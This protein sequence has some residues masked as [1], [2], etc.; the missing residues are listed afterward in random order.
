MTVTIETYK[1]HSASASFTLFGLGPI[2][3]NVDDTIQSQTKDLVIR[4]YVGDDSLTITEQ[5]SFIVSPG[6]DTYSMQL[7]PDKRPESPYDIAKVSFFHSESTSTGT[8]TQDLNKYSILISPTSNYRAT[9]GPEEQPYYLMK[10]GTKYNRTPEN[11]VYYHLCDANGTP[12]TK[13]T[14]EFGAGTMTYQIKAKYNDPKKNTT[15]GKYDKKWEIDNKIYL[16]I[17]DPENAQYESGVYFSYI[18][19]TLMTN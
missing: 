16:E 13:A 6:T 1:T 7:S 9:Y 15:T 12:L 10:D 11:T 3:I 8:T 2:N 14:E 18:Y 5:T 19:F 17:D 4:G